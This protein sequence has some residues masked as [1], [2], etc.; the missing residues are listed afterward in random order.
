LRYARDFVA[1]SVHLTFTVEGLRA[2]LDGRVLVC[3]LLRGRGKDI[4]AEFDA[5]AGWLYTVW[6]GLVVHIRAYMDRAEA[7]EAAGL[8]D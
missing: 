1:Q 2:I 8:A 6:D 7:L 4:T 5:R 3:L